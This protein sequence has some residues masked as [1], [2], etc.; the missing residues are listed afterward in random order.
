MRKKVCK[1][2]RIIV[3]GEKCPLCNGTDFSTNF[4]GRLYILDPVK[5][6]IAKKLNMG[7]K[8]EY[9]IKVR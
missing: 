4:Q 6:K 2:C 7:A 9:A 5:S 3:T 8:G 1:Q